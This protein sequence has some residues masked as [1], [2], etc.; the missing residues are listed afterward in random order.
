MFNILCISLCRKVRLVERGPEF[1]VE[2]KRGSLWVQYLSSES[3]FSAEE[4]FLS[5]A[6]RN[7]LR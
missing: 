6:M 5:F 3:R 4:H 2:F 7:F 1:T